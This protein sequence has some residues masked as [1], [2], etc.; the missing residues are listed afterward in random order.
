MTE[1]CRSIAD[2]CGD[3]ALHI[4]AAETVAAGSC[5]CRPG[6]VG[7]ACALCDSADGYTGM[8]AQ[9]VCE[10]CEPPCHGER[11]ACTWDL[12]ASAAKCACVQGFAGD[13]C[14]DCADGYLMSTPTQ[15]CIACPAGGCGLG[16][17]CVLSPSELETE[18]ECD[19]ESVYIHADPG[20]LRSKC[21]T[22]RA[23]LSPLTCATCPQCP[24]GAYCAEPSAGTVH[25]ACNRGY[26][27][28]AG[29]TNETYD[30]YP[31]PLADVLTRQNYRPDVPAD[32]Q[33]ASFA[34]A[35]QVTPLP[36]PAVPALDLFLLLAAGL[37]G[38]VL[39]IMLATLLC[40]RCRRRRQQ[41]KAE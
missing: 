10:R 41:Q 26:E 34:A 15:E 3:V 12:L 35:T 29:F 28:L 9:G 11:G 32:L 27:R 5:R 4:A 17:T 16:G 13:A 36:P 8:P 19:P 39:F 18:C 14:G 40:W 20:D 22:C 30:C 6:F 7:A 24:V 25:C 2:T 1:Q 37:L 23:N 33:V 38:S 31:S 21:S